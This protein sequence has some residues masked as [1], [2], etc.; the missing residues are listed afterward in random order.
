MSGSYGFSINV[1]L[2]PNDTTNLQERINDYLDEIN[3]NQSQLLKSVLLEDEE[4]MIVFFGDHE[5]TWRHDYSGEVISLLNKIEYT[6]GGKFKGEFFWFEYDFDED[7]IQEWIFDG[8]GGIKY[9]LRT[10]SVDD[11][12]GYDEDEDE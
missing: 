4:D 9:D 10:E 12:Y 6:F 7:I 11:G 5:D 8:E 2:T 1:E 3:N